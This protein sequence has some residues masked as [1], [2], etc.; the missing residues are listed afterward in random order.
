VIE[1]ISAVTL[2]TREM[3][4]AFR[5][6]NSLGFELHYGGAS[7]TF[8][9]FSLGENFLNIEL[10]P[11]FTPSRWGRVIFYVSDVDAMFAR[12][13]E[14]GLEPSTAPHDAAWGERYFH[15]SDPDGHELSFA[16][17]LA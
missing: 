4:A 10:E 1:R 11:D 17:R 6:Y 12:V 13:R 3:A 5:F 16:R 8:T 14:L 2:F 7:A 9:T 15:I